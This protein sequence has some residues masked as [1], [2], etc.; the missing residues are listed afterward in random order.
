[1]G[2]RRKGTVDIGNFMGIINATEQTASGIR[3]S[4]AHMPS[5]KPVIAEG[6]TK[7][8]LM[9]DRGMAETWHAAIRSSYERE[10]EEINNVSRTGDTPDLVIRGQD[11]S[12]PVDAGGGEPT[13]VGVQTIEE[14]LQ[15]S[16]IKWQARLDRVDAQIATLTEERCIS[17]RSLA[18]SEAALQAVLSIDG[19]S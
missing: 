13:P 10:K 11:A 16:C 12:A 18:K 4:G 1:M 8:Q 5:G 3:F 14:Q 6:V 17:M 9:S 19:D 2:N 7:A 15:E